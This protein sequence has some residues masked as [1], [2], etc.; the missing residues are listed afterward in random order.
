MGYNISDV[1]GETSGGLSDWTA[2]LDLSLSNATTIS[3]D[4]DVVSIFGPNQ[5]EAT[6]G[7]SFS[8]LSNPAFGT[9]SFDTN[10]GTYT[11]TP[12]WGAIQATG[13]DQVVS[14]TVTGTS[15]GNS[16]DDTVT[17]S[18]LICVVRGTRIETRKGPVRVEDLVTGDI[19][20]TLDGPAR[21]VRWIGS[22]RV[23]R[24]AQQVNPSLRPVRISAGALGDGVPRHDLR[25]SPQHRVMLQDWRAQLMFGEA[26]VLVPAKS[27]INDGTIR[28]E[29]ARQDVEYFHILF[30]CHEI[31]FTEG[32]PTES[33]HPGKYA[34]RE[35]DCATRSELLTLF[36]ELLTTS[37]YGAAA[38]PSLRRWEAKM[39]AGQR[40]PEPAS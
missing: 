22:R 40:V 12:D 28:I 25:V 32:A 26:Q 14:F 10:V 27:L 8:A 16:D 13:T 29:P 7:Y 35:L 9:L 30:D 5:G 21:P 1:G 37:G 24:R 4:F 15:G 11:F 20:C 18:L 36:P 6:E 3:G 33:F 19:V 39:L 34:L 2:T 23:S 38:R 31:M 17:I